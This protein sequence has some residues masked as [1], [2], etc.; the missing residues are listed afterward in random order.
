VF[1]ESKVASGVLDRGSL[2]AVANEERLRSHA[3]RAQLPDRLQQ[4]VRPLIGCC[5]VMTLV[6]HS[7]ETF[8]LAALESMALAKP[9]VMTDIGGASEQVLHGQNGFLFEPGNI[10]AL[11]A[12][13]SSLTSE[14]LRARMGAAAQRRVRQLFTVDAMTA[15]FTEQMTQLVGDDRSRPTLEH[16]AEQGGYLT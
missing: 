12:H 13:L 6:S 9:L 7:I 2:G 16:P 14:S 5:D 8:S 10:E 1:A 11:A 3:S 15:G 4:D